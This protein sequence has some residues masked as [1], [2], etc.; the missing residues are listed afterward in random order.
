MSDEILTNDVTDPRGEKFIDA[1]AAQDLTLLSADDLRQRLVSLQA[2]VSRTE[3]GL[4]TRAG[5]NVAAEA[6]F[7][8]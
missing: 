3:A 7:K 8:K 1:L 2:E 4:G 5:A 6:L